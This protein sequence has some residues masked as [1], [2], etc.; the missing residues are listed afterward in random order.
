MSP[1][2]SPIPASPWNAGGCAGFISP[3]PVT[4]AT[5][6]RTFAPPSAAAAACSPIARSS[7][8]SPCA[9]H[10]LSFMMAQVRQLPASLDSQRGDRGWP[11]LER[12]AAS[13][14]LLGQNVVLLGLRRH[15]TS[16]RGNARPVQ[17]EDHRRPAPSRRRR[18]RQ[19]SSPRTSSIPPSPPPITSSTSSRKTPPP[20][21]TSTPRALP[22]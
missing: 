21:A 17:R 15:R 10:A 7:T 16:P 4:H 2:A 13:S 5:T 14:L 22:R 9:E 18:E 19:G 11:T 3:P 6:T 20:S 12:R 1:S 8:P